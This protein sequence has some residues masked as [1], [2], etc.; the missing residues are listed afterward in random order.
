MEPKNGK[1]GLDLSDVDHFVL[2]EADR[3]MDQ[4][5]AED[6]HKI[7]KE[8][9]KQ[10]FDILFRLIFNLIQGRS[11]KSP[12]TTVRYAFGHF[13]RRYSRNGQGLDC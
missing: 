4:G 5:F 7:H 8:I 12:T 6:M 2:D 1:V 3:L 9:A 13:R 10:R 11:R